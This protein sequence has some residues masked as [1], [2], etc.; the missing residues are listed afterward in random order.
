MFETCFKFQVLKCFKTNDTE[1]GQRSDDKAFYMTLREARFTSTDEV[2][3]SHPRIHILTTT[4]P[5][6]HQNT[7]ITLSVQTNQ[8]SVSIQIEI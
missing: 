7:L 6:S 1:K 2:D 8:S 4:S 3:G 5:D